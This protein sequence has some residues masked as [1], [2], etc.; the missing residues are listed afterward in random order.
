M[1]D[2]YLRK[3]T[4]GQSHTE[5]GHTRETGFSISVASELMAILALSTSL[6]D[7]VKRISNIV[8][9]RSTG[10]LPITADDLVR[11]NILQTSFFNV[12]IRRNNATLIY[13]DILKVMVKN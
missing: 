5:G 3:I 7:M 12:L 4:I 9:A 1:N 11:I 13:N 2:R 8:V 10:G 6:P